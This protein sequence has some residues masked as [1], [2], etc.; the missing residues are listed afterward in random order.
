MRN[1]VHHATSLCLTMSDLHKI[2]FNHD[3]DDSSSHNDGD[4]SRSH[5][6]VK[7][8]STENDRVGSREDSMYPSGGYQESLS[9][10]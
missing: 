3:N 1:R 10:T 8:V 5:I 4:D 9:L 2:E 6:P 7:K